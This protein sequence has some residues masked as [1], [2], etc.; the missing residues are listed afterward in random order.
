MFGFTGIFRDSVLGT[1]WVFGT[2][3]DVAVALRFS[4]RIIVVT[5]AD[6]VAFV[7]VIDEAKKKL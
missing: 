4:K 6:P 2:H 3:S 7:S 1:Y 5:P